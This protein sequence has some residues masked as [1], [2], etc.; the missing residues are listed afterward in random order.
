MYKKSKKIKLRKLVI[1][2]VE[3]ISKNAKDKDITRYTHVIAPP[4]DLKEAKK[5]IKKT[6]HEM[7][8]KTAYEFGI[9]LKETKKLIGTI[10]LSNINYKNK[11]AEVGFWL[12]KKYW[13]KGLAKETLNLI[14]DFG[15]KKLHLER[16]QAR[17]LNKNLRAQKLL[18]KRGFKLEGRLRRK[19]HFKNKWFDDLIYGILRKEYLRS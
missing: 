1:S 10:S 19:T 14:L 4:F 17:V 18:K 3:F 12:S 2:D 8:E 7:Q 15:F 16:I 13:G 11:N 6:Q 9:E 5:F